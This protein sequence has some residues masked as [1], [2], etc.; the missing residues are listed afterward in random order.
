MKKCKLQKT[1]SVNSLMNLTFAV[2]IV[3]LVFVSIVINLLAKPTDI[4]E[5]VGIKTFRMFTV[6]SNIFVGITMTLTIP[7]SVDGIRNKNY[8]LPRWV[9]NLNFSSVSCISLT[10]L[11]SLAF[12]LK[13]HC[14]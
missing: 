5:E 7:F 1:H 12:R 9:V 14:H 13:N 11:I 6:L 10:F 3:I 8:H 2:V 4:V